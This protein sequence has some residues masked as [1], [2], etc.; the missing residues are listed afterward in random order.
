[1]GSLP[2][3][4]VLDTVYLYRFSNQQRLSMAIKYRRYELVQAFLAHGATIGLEEMKDAV[5][6]GDE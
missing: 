1:M 4:T 5:L 3:W 6:K 2:A